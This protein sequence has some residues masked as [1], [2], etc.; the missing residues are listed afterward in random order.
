MLDGQKKFY[1]FMLSC[2]KEEKVED[3]KNL[4]EESFQRQANKT[5]DMNFLNSFHSQ[6]KDIIREDKMQEVLNILSKFGK[7]HISK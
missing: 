2:A 6:M 7:H 5:F 1:E 3:L 4:L